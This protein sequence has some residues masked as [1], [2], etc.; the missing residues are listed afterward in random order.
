MNGETIFQ[1]PASPQSPAPV[2]Q[3]SVNPPVSEQPIQPPPPTNP[4][5]RR[6]FSIRAIRLLIGL[7]VVLLIGIFIIFLLSK[8]LG[9]SDQKVTITYWGLWEDKSVMDPVIAEFERENPNI[10]VEYSKQD[11][12]EY[13]ERL[14]TRIENGDGPDVFR[15]HNTWYPM[16]S[17]YLLPLPTS[18]ITNDEFSKNFYPVARQDLVRNGAI[19]GIPLQ[20]D[21]LALYINKDMFQAG[22]FSP[23]KTWEEFRNTAYEL[24]VKDENGS[25]KTSGAAIGTYENIVH[26]P[27]I[28]SLL[29][30]Q[31][32]VN[33]YKLEATQRLY[34]GL[35]FYTSFAQGDQEIWNSTLDNSLLS[36]SRG[37]LGM[38][39]GYSWDYFAIKAMN[40]ELNFETVPVPQLD[41]ENPTA[42]ASYW[43]EGVS[44]ESK[45]QKE[46]LMF[47]KFLSEASTQEKLYSEEAKTRLFGEPYSNVGLS[48]K[49]KENKEVYP[50][51][52]QAP[53]AYS[54]YFVDSTEDNG[55]NQR[56]GNYMKDAV[57]FILT[58]GSAESA[59]ETLIEGFSQVLIQYEKKE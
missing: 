18:V 52:E 36:F 48:Q 39:F 26:A 53:Y 23:P 45:N 5:R 54:S 1:N 49:L 30:I 24:T 20:I 11:I 46:A 3:P 51:V 2:E 4:Q 28:I 6:L 42:L 17:S 41:S 40:P 55:L 19:Y 27:D 22:G 31:N 34:D 38:Y 44:T 29:L 33:V 50:F 32:G 15:F 37:S 9:G 59:S 14:T 13:R 43:A 47:I 21:T 25:I 35:T 10:D 58:G 16:F 56:L 57:N 8:I 12:K 7:F